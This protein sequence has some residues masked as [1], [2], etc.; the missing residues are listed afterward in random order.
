MKKLL[1]LLVYALLAVSLCA[2]SPVVL[3]SVFD[4]PS[5]LYS[6]SYPSDTWTIEES[7]DLNV[8]LREINADAEYDL[9]TGIDITLTPFPFTDDITDLGSFMDFLLPLLVDIMG[10][11]GM[12]NTKV[13]SE[14]TI[15]M[16]GVELYVLRIS[17]TYVDELIVEQYVGLV[18]GQLF[19]MSLASKASTFGNYANVFSS[20]KN[21]V[22]FPKR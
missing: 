2:L 12:T 8:F 4:S 16:D 17:G 19:I 20:V 13:A 1:F 14:G 5:K 10:E 11:Q 6:I 22:K 21:S 18:R 15:I 9:A 7:D 3:N